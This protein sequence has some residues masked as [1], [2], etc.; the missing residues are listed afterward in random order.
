M[1]FDPLLSGRNY[2]VPQIDNYSEEMQRRMADMQHA[3]KPIVQPK[4]PVWDEIDNIVSGMSEAEKEYLA[5]DEAYQ[6]SSAAVN[7]VLQREIL[8]SMRPVVEST[9]DGKAALEAHLVLLKRIQK[10]AKDEAARRESLMN[11]Y[12]MNHS[13]MSWQDFIAMKQGKT[14]KKTKK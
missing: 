13:D 11:E 4:S 2:D 9:K 7:A 8:R 14:N 3:W 1:M 5:S 10:Q 6:E 12:I